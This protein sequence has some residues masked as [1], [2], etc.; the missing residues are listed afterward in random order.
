MVDHFRTVLVFEHSDIY[1]KPENAAALKVLFCSFV[2]CMITLICAVFLTKRALWT[3]IP[4]MYIL[5]VS[6]MG[7]GIG[8]SL[9]QPDSRAAT[10]IAAAVIIPSFFH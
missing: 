7:T 9:V 3:R 5:E 10:I 6:V 2:I 1:N 8:L 4:L